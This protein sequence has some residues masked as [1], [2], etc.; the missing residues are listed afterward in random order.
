MRYPK[1]C[2]LK[3][4]VEAVI[5]PLEPGDRPLLD[6]FYNRIP[7]SDRWFLH[8]L[9]RPPAIVVLD[10]YTERIFFKNSA[11]HQ[12]IDEISNR[13]PQDQRE[14]REQ[15][16][17]M[18]WNPAIVG[19]HDRQGGQAEHRVERPEDGVARRRK[20]RGNRRTRRFRRRPGP[21][22]RSAGTAPGRRR[23]YEGWR[24]RRS[25]WPTDERPGGSGW[26]S[27]Q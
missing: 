4:C 24:S 2:V 23:C 15:H 12:A 13:T 10:S 26:R 21:P 19:Q 11:L 27:R 20:A 17:L 1:E 8:Y 7:E 3:E 9:D 14:R 25:R 22:W 16:R 6:D 18:V 5:R